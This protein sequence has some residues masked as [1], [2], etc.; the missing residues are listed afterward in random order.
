LH[1]EAPA[2]ISKIIKYNKVFKYN[3]E[4]WMVNLNDEQKYKN[5]DFFVM[6]D[7]KTNLLTRKRG[8]ERYKIYPDGKMELIKKGVAILHQD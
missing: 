6:M 4:N 1:S 7:S 5:K 8:Y 3:V 2:C